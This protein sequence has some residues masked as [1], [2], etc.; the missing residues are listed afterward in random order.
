[1]HM[2]KGIKVTEVAT[3]WGSGMNQLTTG[4][5][6]NQ[7]LWL[8]LRTKSFNTHPVVIPLWIEP[9]AC[10]Y[11]DLGHLFVFREKPRCTRLAGMAW[12]TS[13]QNSCSK[14]PTQTCR[15]RRLC[16][17][18]RRSCPRQAPWTMSI[19]KR[20]CIWQLPIIIQMWYLSSWSRKVSRWEFCPSVW[21]VDSSLG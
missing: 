13:Q 8:A 12:P 17:C 19:Y 15:Q 6:T 11:S 10:R 3:G 14:V 20:H 18:Q 21:L 7:G 1:M 9:L 5:R 16:L 4:N 2:G